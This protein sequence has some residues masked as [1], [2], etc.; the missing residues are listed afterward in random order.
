MI[1]HS[2]EGFVLLN[3]QAT[4]LYVNPAVG[5]MCGTTSERLIGKSIFQWIHPGDLAT[6]RSTYRRLVEEPGSNRSGV[7]RV[8]QPGG[9]VRWM[10]ASGVNLLDD[11]VVSGIVVMFHDPQKNT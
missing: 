2:P 6:V 4:L 10:E 1:E 3:S 11:P 7:F 5:R 9:S 8:C